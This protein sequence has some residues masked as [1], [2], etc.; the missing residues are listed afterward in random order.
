MIRT[1]AALFSAALVLCAAVSAQAPVQNQPDQG[2]NS[3]SL[4]TLLRQAQQKANSVAIATIGSCPVAMQAKQGGMTQ[5][6]KTGQK[7]PQPQQYAP[8]PKPAQHILLILSGFGK[9]KS[10]ASATVTA[11]G[12][13]SRSRM[14][15]LDLIGDGSS[16][17]RRTMKV[18]F[19]PD[20]DGSVSA[21][22]DLPAFTAVNSLQLQ[23]ITY[24][25]G[26]NWKLADQHMCWVTPDPMMLIAAQ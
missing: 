16:D 8:A 10:V 19:T 11:R 17:L 23:S 21:Y 3:A 24:S 22:I 9:D 6:V 1:A 20:P 14:Q 12:L 15:N 7:P 13:S 4:E 26:S 18:T 5:M 2:N 25:D